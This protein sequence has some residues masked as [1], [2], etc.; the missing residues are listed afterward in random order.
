MNVI[1][2]AVAA[3][4]LSL[5]GTSAMAEVYV[6]VSYLDGGLEVMD[7]LDVDLPTVV[8]RGGYGVS[9]VLALEVRGGTGISRDKDVAGSDVNIEL[10]DFVGGYAVVRMPTATKVTPYVLAGYTRAEFNA[11]S[12]WGSEDEVETDFSYGFGADMAL[13]ESFAV[14]AEWVTLV[15]K[16]DV[17]FGGLSVGAT[18]AF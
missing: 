3:S 6:G 12:N 15:D 7:S 9:E 10:E 4:A 8:I 2:T 18:L 13:T 11:K 5:M 16:G 17:E 1:K 14:N